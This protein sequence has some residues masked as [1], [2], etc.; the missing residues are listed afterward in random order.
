MESLCMME[1]D[2]AD[3][4]VNVSSGVKRRSTDGRV[5]SSLENV[6]SKHAKGPSKRTRLGE[7]I[8]SAELRIVIIGKTGTGKSATANTILGKCIFESGTSGC[9]L[10][11]KCQTGFTTRTD[12]KIVVVDTPGLFDTEMTNAEVTQ[13]IVKCINMTAP[14][15]HAILLTVNVGRFTEEEQKT[16]KHFVDHFG[17]GIYNYLLIVFTRADE[18]TTDMEDF[19]KGCPQSLKDILKRCHNRYISFNNKLSGKPLERQVTD[20]ID[21]V[22][23]V[24]RKNDDLCY[25]NEMYEEAKKTL[26]RYLDDVRRKMEEEK[27]RTLKNLKNEL[28]IEFD[29]KL[30]MANDTM[31]EENRKLLD[32]INKIEIEKENAKTSELDTRNEITALKNQLKKMRRQKQSRN[33]KQQEEQLEKRLH[34]LE[35]KQAELIL[36]AAKNAYEDEIAQLKQQME[37]T[38]RREE[39]QTDDLKK[40]NE[41]KIQET[42]KK[43][44]AE[45]KK[46]QEM[47]KNNQAMKKQIQE[48]DKKNQDAS[49]AR[50]GART[51]IPLPKKLNGRCSLM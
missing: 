27:Q 19:I 13:E 2:C 49:F 43:Y 18:L 24:V 48:M 51:D 30:T 34:D 50:N 8:D 12:R 15:P 1:T 26:Q 20:L 5:S 9:S 16:V 21:K 37:D 11:S 25:T 17:D 28:Q 31:N 33:K 23:E 10:T 7:V 6:V 47:N 3:D 45:E 40:E 41:R 36:T 42:E 46:N 14:G 4:G 22:D 35:I 39:Q 38:K 44:Q 29:K 32:R